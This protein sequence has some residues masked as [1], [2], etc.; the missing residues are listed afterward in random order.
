MGLREQADFRFG[1]RV[2]EERERRGWSQDELAKRLA[3]KG[4]PVYAST[5]AKIESEKKP[6]PARLGEAAVIADLFEVPV[7]VLIDRRDPQESLTFAL[8]TLSGYIRDVER[9]AEQAQRVSANIG[10]QLEEAKTSFELPHIEDLQRVAR[11]MEGH[12]NDAHARAS[13]LNSMVS[14]A[15]VQTA[16]EDQ[17][18]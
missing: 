3:D 13:T 14:E 9:Q 16:E 11:D 6:R 7:D 1:R 18:R 5:I 17:I 2:R 12:L 10:Q 15:I 8:V 4:I